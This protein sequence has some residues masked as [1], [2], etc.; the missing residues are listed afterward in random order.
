V[1][2]ELVAAAVPEAELAAEVV[3]IVRA[4]FGREPIVEKKHV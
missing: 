1:A 2:G 4:R 3:R